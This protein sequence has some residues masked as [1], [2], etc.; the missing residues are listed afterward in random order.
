M[1]RFGI[2]LAAMAAALPGVAMAEDAQVAA[3]VEQ[4]YDDHLEDLFVWFHQNPEL[5]FLETNT[6]ARM[7]AE[8]RAA[9]LQVTEGVGRTGVVGM[10]ENGEGPL[11][12]IRADMDGLPV[13]ERSGLEY[14]SQARQVGQDGVEYPVMHACGHDVHITSMVG[15]AHQLMAMRDRWSGTLMFVVQPAEERIGGARAMLEDGLWL[16]LARNANRV[17]K[18]LAEGL[19]GRGV[20]ISYPV[21]GNEVFAMLEEP[22]V[23][24]LR[25]AGAVFYPWPDGSQRLVCSWSTTEDQINRFLQ[26]LGD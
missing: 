9:G 4:Q 12:L 22:D 25:K 14:A 20:A 5:S 10:V 6:A 3:A 8:L 2:A 26:V 17:A 7:A 11:I 13:D 18:R 24:D 19:E 23:T 16:E 15:T 21:D 1:N